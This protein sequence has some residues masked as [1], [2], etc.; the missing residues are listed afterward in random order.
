[1]MERDYEGD[2]NYNDYYPIIMA[3]NSNLQLPL[4]SPSS[5]LNI[6]EW[7]DQRLE[8]IEI[9]KGLIEVLQNTGFT[10]EKVLECGPSHIAEI[11]GIDNYIGE[12]IYQ[13]TKKA[14][15]TIISS[16]NF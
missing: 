8:L 13:E 15:R 5:S 1:M 10:V 16:S 11:L 14:T 2:N 12:L 7:K 9:P 4:S 6:A 3:K